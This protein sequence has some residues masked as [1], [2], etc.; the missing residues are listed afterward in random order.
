MIKFLRL[1]NL[2]TIEDVRIDFEDGFS[3]LTGETGAG[4]SIIIDG[5]RLVCGEKGSADLVRSGAE[6]ASVEAVFSPSVGTGESG[7]TDEG[8][9]LL[10]RLLSPTSGKAYLNGVL[11]PLKKIK[12]AAAGLVD[13][14]GQNDHV[15]LLQT[16]SH[17][18]YLDQYAGSGPLR[19]ETIRTA[20][21]VREL[22]RRREEW[23]SK[24][25]ERGQRLD[26]LE[27][28][29]AEIEKAGLRPGEE[30]EL[31]A[32]R[33]LFRNAEKIRGLVEEAYDLAYGGDASLHAVLGR[34]AAHL[35]ELAPYDP[36]FRE[37]RDALSPFAITVGELSDLLVRFRDREEESPERLEEI[38][39]RLS[40]IERFKRK[41]GAEIGEIQSYL[42]RL[43]S[44]REDYLRIQDRL[45]QAGEE[46]ARAA[47]AYDESS[48]K[49]SAVRREAARKLGDKIEKEIALLGMKKAR[50][51]VGVE[52][53]PFQPER[54][55]TARDSGLDTVEFLISPNPGEPPKPLRKIASGGELSRIMLALKSA[56]QARDEASTLIFDEIDAGIG[57]KTAESVAQKLKALSARHQ[58]LCITHL[59]QIASFASHHYLISKRTENNRT[60][61]AVRKLGIDQRVEELARLM[62]GSLVTETS[63]ASARDMLEHNTRS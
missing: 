2:A 18:I 44:E 22:V 5:I 1:R 36:A 12:D 14:Y 8:D 27:F 62:S 47:A 37:A 53:D 58:V 35:E 4:K 26:F 45:R 39:E 25:R 56:A 52:T 54:P 23:Q 9:I 7:G 63:L 42:D 57:G 13:V 55:E 10:Q 29:I 46:I 34:L 48:R 31:R 32:K 21:E 59:P 11:V 38:E 19:E 40:L 24:E 51:E 41:Y 6:E 15:F 43:K 50:F 20:R 16:E 28:Q 33:L 17:R 30:E 61:T 60:F 49:L 3:V